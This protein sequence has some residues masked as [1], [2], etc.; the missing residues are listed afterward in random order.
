MSNSLIKTLSF[1]EEV[2]GI[3]KVQE[4]FNEKLSDLFELDIKTVTMNSEIIETSPLTHAVCTIQSRACTT[5]V[6]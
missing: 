5:M 6:C 4:D 1:S 3:N 2:K